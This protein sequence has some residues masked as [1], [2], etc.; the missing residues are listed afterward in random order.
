MEEKKE[1][2][3]KPVVMGEFQ[4]YTF[5][6]KNREKI[7]LDEE[8]FHLMSQQRKKKKKDSQCPVPGVNLLF[9]QYFVGSQPADT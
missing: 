8:P 3:Y 7:V 6:S 2:E 4:F 1:E 9:G 5:F